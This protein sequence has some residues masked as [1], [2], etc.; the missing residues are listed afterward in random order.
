M[1][2]TSDLQGLRVAILAPISWPTPPAGYGPWE[3][4]AADLADGMRRR[5][6]DVT[7]FATGNSRFDG[8]VRSVIDVGFNEDPA[9]NGE[10]YTAL[11]IAALFESAHDFDII[12]NSFDWKPLTYAR[13][14]VAPPLV[15]TI[16]GFSSPAILA[17]YYAC[18]QRSFF[19]SISDADRDPG[20]S[21]AATVHNGVRF[22]DFTFVDKPGTYL[23]FLGRFHEEKGA[24]LAIEIAKRT[25]YPLKIAAIP[26][27][28]EY[29]RTAVEPHIDGVQIQYVGSVERA[30]R[31]ELL[32]NALA[33]VHMTTRPERFGLTMI[34]AMACGTPVLGARMGSIPEIVVDGVTG[35][36]CDSVDAAVERVPAC[37]ALERSAC[38]NH[39]AANFSVERMIDGYVN[40][41]RE[42]LR[43]GKPPPP[44]AENLRAR[45]H[46]WWDRPMAFT[47]IPERPH[48][49]RFANA[50]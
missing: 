13:A 39:V 32:G 48:S 4:V 22:S 50:C 7:L 45:A 35:F 33:L 3:Q 18:A 38:R 49:L 17:A 26:Q 8:R 29:F 41:Y 31:N 30:A 25:G 15:T 43:L 16:H 47:D 6:L 40:V 5:G 36:L 24:H 9:L 20:L 23:L 46:D 44:T 1:S 2:I 19:C 14:T 11:H 27:D 12:H 28:E 37:A 42:V 10:V 21:Y 34:E